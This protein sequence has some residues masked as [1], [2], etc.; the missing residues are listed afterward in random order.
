MKKLLLIA[1]VTLSILL[2]IAAVFFLIPDTTKLNQTLHTVKLDANGNEIGSA[3][4]AMQGSWRDYRLWEDSHE[5]YITP[6]DGISSISS[7]DNISG[8]GTA[9]EDLLHIVYGVHYSIPNSAGFMN[10]YISRDFE[11]WAFCITSGGNTVYYVGS[12]SGTR[13]TRDIQQFFGTLI[14]GSQSA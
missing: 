10:V 11:Y 14:P 5:L 9:G 12:A 8:A 4:I 13:T 6:F 2:L 7:S 3:D 1:C